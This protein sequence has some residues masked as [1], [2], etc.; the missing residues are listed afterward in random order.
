MLDLSPN[1]TVP[2]HPDPE[3]IDLEALRQIVAGFREMPGAMLP[4]LHTIQGHLG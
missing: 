3:P 2:D 1:R 4:L